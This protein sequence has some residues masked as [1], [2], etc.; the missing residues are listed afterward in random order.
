MIHF[1][2]ETEN[3]N[4]T[5]KIW[6]NDLAKKKSHLIFESDVSEII[7]ESQD[8]VNSLE[9]LEDLNDPSLEYTFTFRPEYK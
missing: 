5:G 3:G 7:G 6:Y 9:S 2:A 4:Q 8:Y 1:I